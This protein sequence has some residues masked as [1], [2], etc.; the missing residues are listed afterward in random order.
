MDWIA[1]FDIEQQANKTTIKGFR[2]LSILN[3]IMLD[4][5]QTSTKIEALREEIRLM[6]EREGSAKAIAFSQFTS[7]LDL[8]NYTL[9]KCR[10]G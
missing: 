6:V 4:D 5:F 9:G 3:R 10:F 8:I 1:K 7:F 2:A